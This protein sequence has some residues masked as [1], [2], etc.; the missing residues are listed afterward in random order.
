MGKTVVIKFWN[1]GTYGEP[2]K[3]CGE[4]D[5]FEICGAF[6]INHINYM[7]SSKFIECVDYVNLPTEQVLVAEGVFCEGEDGEVFFD[8]GEVFRNIFN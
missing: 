2:E 5:I 8:M 1:H 4:I 6:H 7:K 3:P